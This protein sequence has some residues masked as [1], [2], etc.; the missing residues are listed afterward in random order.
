MNWRAFIIL[1]IGFCLTSWTLAEFAEARGGGGRGGGR[2]GGSVSRGGGGGGG[3]SRGGGGGSYG[4]IRN[5]GG[6]SARNFSRGSTRDISR[7]STRDLSRPSQGQVSDRMGSQRPATGGDRLSQGLPSQL[8]AAGSDTRPAAGQLPAKGGD[9]LGQGQRPGQLPAAGIGTGAS[10]RPVGERGQNLS[11]AQKDQLRQKYQE[12]G[13]LK[14]SQL[15]ARGEDWQNNREDIREDWQ[16]YRNEAREDW[17]DWYEDEYH[18]HW[19]DH[20]YSPWWYGYPVSTVSYAFYIDDTPP[21]QKTVLINQATGSTT[22]YYCNSMWYQPAYSAGEV[23]YIVTAPPAGA[24]LTTLSDPYKVTVRGEDYF[25]SN[26]VF[27]QKITRDG[28]TLY[29]TVDAPPGARVPTIPEYAV[30]INHQGQS[31]YRFDKIFY[32]K[33]GDFFLVVDNPGV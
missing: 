7:P 33:Q 11:S 22:Y 10:Q 8:P 18:D 27:Y 28:Q 12:S 1:L 15:P 32:Q 5:S 30:E 17:Q 20:W 25:V 2:G 4:S 13:G 29:V 3:F 19:D 31:Y 23:K 14:A 26:H 21:C 9:R 6:S 16:D 24:E